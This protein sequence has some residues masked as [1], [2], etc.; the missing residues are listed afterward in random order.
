M[1][2]FENI[3]RSPLFQAGASLLNPALGAAIAQGQNNQ[4]SWDMTQMAN[5][6]S[7]ASSAQQ[8]VFQERMSN[9]SHQRE[10]A[11]L[12]AAGLNPILSSNAGAS[13]PGGSQMTAQVPEWK[14]PLG[15]GI[16]TAI[17]SA[18]IMTSLMSAASAVKLN[19][20]QARNLDAGTARTGIDIK[21]GAPEADMMNDVGNI[22]KNVKQRFKSGAW[23]DKGYN[24]YDSS[25]YGGYS[26][27]PIQQNIR[28]NKRG[29]R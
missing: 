6:A 5:D 19:N 28:I 15:K 29:N 26:Q 21:R 1:G 24:R 12:K 7:Q 10:V 22:W 16:D 14:S 8:M 18:K 13:S 17:E 25:E 20:A 27:K 3:G 4:A 23:Q 11:D 9:T 2:L